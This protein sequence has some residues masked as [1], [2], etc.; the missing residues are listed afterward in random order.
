VKTTK[1]SVEVQK[2]IA[3]TEIVDR[4][5]SPR[6]GLAADWP[7]NI[8]YNGCSYYEVSMSARILL[9]DGYNLLYAAGMGQRDYKP[10]DLLR[11]RTLLQ[12]YLLAKLSR[13]EVRAATLI[14]DARHPPP[15][16][17]SES[18]VSGLK[19]LFANPGGDADVMIQQWL[20]RH[21]TPRRVTLVSSDRALQ[22]SARAS[23]AK[24]VRSEAFL[25]ELERRRTKT[26][27]QSPDADQDSKPAT[28]PG[29]VQTAYWLEVF[30]GALNVEHEEQPQAESEPVPPGPEKS[31]AKIAEPIRG[32]PPRRRKSRPRDDSK[33]TGSIDPAELEEWLKVFGGAIAEDN[34]SPEELRRA[35]LEKWLE[36][37]QK[38]NDPK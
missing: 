14:Y 27:K 13:A 30:E 6:P 26:G 16:R 18:V 5:A 33:P 22:R 11:C 36:Q 38:R 1:F 34:A 28:Q 31:A 19:V 4:L 21:P 32:R 23:G 12:K 9:I 35:E 8:R 7:R 10:G 25:V 15:D 3:L 37:E 20:S 2:P 24:F 29:D 17:P